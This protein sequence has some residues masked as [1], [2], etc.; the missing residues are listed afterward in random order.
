MSITSWKPSLGKGRNGDRCQTRLEKVTVFDGVRWALSA[1]GRVPHRRNPQTCST[2]TPRG[3][4]SLWLH[5]VPAG[6]MQQSS[7]GP[8]FV[9]LGD[10]GQRLETLSVV[11]LREASSGQ[12]SG[13][14]LT[15]LQSSA[16]VEQAG[17]D[18]T[19]RFPVSGGGL[20][21]SLVTPAWGR[22]G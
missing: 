2:S 12:K 17:S 5:L 11:I 6:L 4:E 7:A 21:L 14:L 8:D 9:F 22:M 18:V 1:H 19:Q 15:T 10:T 16:G 13:I 20:F 3:N